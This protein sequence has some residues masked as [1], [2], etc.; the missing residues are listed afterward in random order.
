MDTLDRVSMI[1]LPAIMVF[2][3]VLAFN[4]PLNQEYETSEKISDRIL[5]LP[6]NT[7]ETSEEASKVSV[8]MSDEYLFTSNKSKFWL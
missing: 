8:E 2:G 5:N 3:L 7:T 4:L 6:T 1:G